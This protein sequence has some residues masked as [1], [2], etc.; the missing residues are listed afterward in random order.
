[1]DGE[2]MKPDEIWP[3]WYRGRQISTNGEGEDARFGGESYQEVAV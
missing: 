1:M 2:G 3:S